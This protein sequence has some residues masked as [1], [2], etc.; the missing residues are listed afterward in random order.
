MRD[1]LA[2]AKDLRPLSCRRV[3]WGFFP[4]VLVDCQNRRMQD[5]EDAQS[6][7]SPQVE[8]ETHVNALN[9]QWR[10]DHR[11]RVRAI[12]KSLLAGQ[13]SV[14]EAEKLLTSVAAHDS[15]IAQLLGDAQVLLAARLLALVD[16]PA[17]LLQVS[18]SLK[19]ATSCRNAA[20]RRAAETLQVVNTIKAQRALTTPKPETRHLKRV[21]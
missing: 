18:R 1:A 13:S 14:T 6:S 5:H 3:D 10:R 11:K 21:A 12:E 2:A 8:F 9:R 19:D 20:A 15:A 17:S 16:S 7:P 4:F